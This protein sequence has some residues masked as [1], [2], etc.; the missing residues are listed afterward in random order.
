MRERAPFQPD[1]LDALD[2]LL[3]QATAV[4]PMIDI[5]RGAHDPRLIG[6]RHDVDNL[7]EPAVH[8]AQWEAARGYRAT[9]FILHTAPY[10][11]NKL[12]LRGALELIAGCGHEIG[13]HNNALAEATRTG[14][15]PG[16]ILAAAVGELRDLGY[17]IRG[18]V[19]HGDHACYRNGQVRFVNDE[20]FVECARPQYGNLDLSPV[21][22]ATFGL[23]YDA[24]WIPR[25]SY[26]SDSGG[27]W[28]RPFDT[29]RVPPAAGQLHMLVHPDW[30]PEAFT[31]LEA[32][33]AL[34]AMR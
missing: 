3:E 22:L 9:Y 25:G 16:M 19:A 1:D 12:L 2:A 34:E 24:N 30:W 18:T 13:I 21:P 5:H 28:S 32:P 26:L 20:L 10:W 27:A 15:D 31:R 17:D 11:E 7:I 4:L 29:I 8:M 23:E 6:L 33:A 14:R